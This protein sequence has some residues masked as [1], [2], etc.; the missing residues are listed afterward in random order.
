MRH[1][2]LIASLL[3]A[4][5]SWAGLP[6]N[7][8]PDN[9]LPDNGLPD[10]G[11]PDNGLP[12]NGNSPDALINS[13][14]FFDA[15]THAYW[16][17]NPFT[18]DTINAGMNPLRIALTDPFSAL[19]MAYQWQLCH[20][21][22]DDATVV[23]SRGATHTFHGR[24]GLCV[25]ANGHGWHKDQPLDYDTARWLS[26][27]TITQV[28]RFQVHNRYSLRGPTSDL[29]LPGGRGNQLT[30]MAGSMT[31]YIYKFGTDLPVAALDPCSPPGAGLDPCGWK[32][33]FVGLGRP[34]ST[35]QVS[36]NSNGVRMILQAN[37]GIHAAD[38]GSPGAI[39]TSQ[40]AINP[41]VA[42]V[43]P[44][45]GT[46]NVQWAADP[47]PDSNGG[48][49]SIAPPTLRAR[50]VAGG[51]TLR[52]PADEVFVFANREM[53]S[54]AMLFN[55]TSVDANIA[56]IPGIG[57]QGQPVANCGPR[58]N[59]DGRLQFCDGSVRDGCSACR[60]APARGQ[61]VFPNAHM[62]LSSSWTDAQ[63]YYALRSC[64]SDL[65][66]CV[67]TFEGF[68]DDR[69]CGPG[70]PHCLK[71]GS[72]TV[73][74]RCDVQSHDRDTAKPR[75]YAGGARKLDDASGCHIGSGPDMGYGVTTFFANYGSDGA[76]WASSPNDPACR[77]VKRGS[78]DGED[79]D[80]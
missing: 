50:V 72:K 5:N 40:S 17:G 77:Y 15:A 68:I 42:F 36:A 75:P 80:D 4:A 58:I 20:P 12:D 30:A 26:S 79:D 66:T 24:V 13:P 9:G 38:P 25:L 64:S 10:N 6:D 46:F 16:V 73:S 59:S 52:F 71:P 62:W 69:Y 33:H 2:T 14:L 31:S 19:V 22:G 43:V 49:A 35:V 7:G 74:R 47:R 65:S 76:C 67:A 41:A 28:N 3:L 27:S 54:T 34:G 63:D 39:A 78:G 60:R 57:A 61:V 44:Q 51:G 11:L 55:L 18:G 29:S 37:L 1:A 8:L 48:P 56:A 23:D 70:D 32:P 45:G 53:Y 21:T